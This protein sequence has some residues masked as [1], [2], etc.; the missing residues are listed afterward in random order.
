MSSVAHEQP[1]SAQLVIFNTTYALVY[2]GMVLCGAILIFDRR[3][4]Q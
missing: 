1:V 3:D 2:V 4:F